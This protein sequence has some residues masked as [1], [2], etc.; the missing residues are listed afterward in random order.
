MELDARFQPS[1]DVVT[2]MVGDELV[3]LDYRG[4]VY[5]GLDPVGTRVWQL[6]TEGATYARV[7]ETLMAEHEVSREQL[8]ADVERLIGD[9]QDAGLLTRA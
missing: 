4:E 9:L 5:Y 8:S 1:A 2:K 3:L 6:V 7:I